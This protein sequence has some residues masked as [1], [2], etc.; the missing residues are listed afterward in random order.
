M[1]EQMGKALHGGIAIG[2]I[3]YHQKKTLNVKRTRIDSPQ[4]EYKRYCNARESAII[5]LQELYTKAVKEVGEINAGIF[6]VHQL[7]LQDVEFD[8][9]VKN[10]IF[11]QQMNAEYAVAITGDHL[12]SM[13]EEMEDEYFRSKAA[14]IKDVSER[15]I[16]ILNDPELNGSA[17]DQEDEDIILMAYDLAPS[18]TVQLDKSKIRAFV[19][20]EGSTNSHTA[21]LARTMNI[22]ALVGIEYAE[23]MQGKTAIVDGWNSMF[24]VDPDEEVLKHFREKRDQD[25]RDRD[26]LIHYAN[27]K[28]MTKSGKEIHLYANIGGVSD[29]SFVKKNGAEGIGLFRSEFLYLRSEERR[30]GKEC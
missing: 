13:F 29:L 30:V 6:E 27:K 20:K 25:E 5:E 15:V 14:D 2:R 28:T 12:S 11:E 24:L 10:I 21:I 18:E 16:R 26:L 23:D 1:Q 22:P 8:D 17:E 9:S 3:E 19:T 4:V 7:M